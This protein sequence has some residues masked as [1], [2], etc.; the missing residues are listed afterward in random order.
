MAVRIADSLENS[1]HFK[2]R[3][4]Y[5]ERARAALR[6][7]PLVANDIVKSR[8]V[9]GTPAARHEGVLERAALVDVESVERHVDGMVHRPVVVACEDVETLVGQ[10]EGLGSPSCLLLGHPVNRPQGAFGFKLV[11]PRD[12]RARDNH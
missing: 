11:R 6:E 12:A 7:E 3:F 10:R 8:L 2:T 4:H 9:V 1:L 5:G